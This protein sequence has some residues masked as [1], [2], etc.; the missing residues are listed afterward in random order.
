[1]NQIRSIDSNPLNCYSPRYFTLIQMM[2][3]PSIFLLERKIFHY[4]CRS[5]F[6]HWNRIRKVSLL[7]SFPIKLCHWLVFRSLN[8]YLFTLIIIYWLGVSFFCFLGNNENLSE[9]VCLF[10]TAIEPWL[11]KAYIYAMSEG[12]AMKKPNKVTCNWSICISKLFV[13]IVNTP[14]N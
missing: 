8:K 14:F 9:E 1:M 12:A 2:I 11:I 13:L 4:S 6:H 7:L 10:I 3:E 5:Y